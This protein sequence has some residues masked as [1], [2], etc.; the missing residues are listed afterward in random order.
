MATYVVTQHG[1]L[2]TDRRVGTTCCVHLTGRRIT[3]FSSEGGGE[4]FLQKSKI[5]TK[6]H[7]VNV[8]KIISLTGGFKIGKNSPEHEVMTGLRLWNLSSFSFCIPNERHYY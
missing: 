7:Y 6:V 5:S 1:A 4:K 2:E 8:Q 3:F